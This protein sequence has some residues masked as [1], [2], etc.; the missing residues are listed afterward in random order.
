MKD[1]KVQD[2]EFGT[3][4]FALRIIR[5]YASQNVPNV[6]VIRAESVPKHSEWYVT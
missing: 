4:E 2:L 6:P 5:L 1:E 3:K